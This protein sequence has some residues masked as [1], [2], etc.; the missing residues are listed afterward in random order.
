V[1]TSV[2]AYLVDVSFISEDKPKVKNNLYF[3]Y[4]AFSILYQCSL[5]SR[6]KY[7]SLFFF[8][9]SAKYSTKPVL[10]PKP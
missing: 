5:S 8:F 2:R 7:L 3:F 10:D 6:F 1:A 4:A 9:L